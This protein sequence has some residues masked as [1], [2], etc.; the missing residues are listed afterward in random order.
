MTS[1]KKYTL[2]ILLFSTILFAQS[3]NILQKTAEIKTGVTKSYPVDPRPLLDKLNKANGIDPTKSVNRTLLRKTA[4]NFVVGSTKSWR[5][6]NLQTSNYYDLPSTCRSVGTNCY[7]FVE[8]ASWGSRVTQSAVD[9]VQ[10][11]FDLKT[12]ANA[13]KGIYT[14]N[15]ETFGNPPNNDGDSRIIIIILDIKDG[16]TADPPGK[17]Y[18]AGFFDPNNE[19]GASGNLPSEIYHLDCNPLDLSSTTSLTTGMQITA[20]E[21]QHMIH[22]NYDR[23]EDTFINESMSMAAEVV[24]GYSMRNQGTFNNETNHYLFDWRDN[25]STLVLTD[26]SRA[27][28]FS[29]YFYEQFGADILKRIVQSSSTQINGINTALQN[30][31]PST[32]RRFADILGDWFVANILNNKAYDSRYGYTNTAAGNAIAREHLNPNVTNYS[33]A[34]YKYGAQYI[35]YSSGSNLQINFDTKGNS[36]VKIKAIKTGGAGTVVES[37]SPGSLYSVPTFGTEYTKVTFVVYITDPSAGTAPY[38][39][40]YTSS[41]T[42]NSIPEDILYSD[43]YYLFTFGEGNYVAGTNSLKTRGVYER[44]D[45]PGSAPV[46]EIRFYFGKKTVNGTAD[47]VTY[48]IRSVNAQ[49]G[50]GTILYYS[51][52]TTQAFK[53]PVNS[54]IQPTAVAISPQINVSNSFFVGLEWTPTNDDV[55]SL[56]TDNASA[57]PG[58]GDG[59]RRA[60]WMKNDYTFAF[61]GD[62][63]G[64]GGFDADLAIGVKLDVSTDVENNN[65]VNEIPASYSLNQNYPNPFNPSTAISYQLSAASHV[66]LKVYDMLGREVATLVDEFQNAGKY[67]SK[68]S[69]VNSQFSSGIYFYTIRAGNFV[70]TKKM[71]LLK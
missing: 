15:V 54:L 64:S 60:W 27:A 24:N 37:L 8:D 2:L 12:P 39:F 29:I 52:A 40:S 11:A 6:G 46:K 25:N 41:G 51:T 10:Q 22:Y 4:W 56:L 65:N 9:A 67:N 57:T 58:E 71:M 63:F 14:T 70:E 34:V 13:N 32:T 16:W 18:T 31:T 61:I 35:S 44:F 42:S 48:A 47:N 1:Y 49:G 66:S 7:I 45:I 26:Y 19:T 33:D 59:K 53:L 62:S 30:V 17:G 3:Q 28:R 23:N 55:F 43:S 69:T 5:V 20:H 50:P 38:D 36:V 21:F 68:F